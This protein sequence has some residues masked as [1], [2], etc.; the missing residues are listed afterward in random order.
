MDPLSLQDIH[1]LAVLR[2]ECKAGAGVI[3]IMSD[4]GG[5]WTFDIVSSLERRIP[6]DE[7]RSA[8][9]S[10]S[11]GYVAASDSASLF[12]L[13]YPLVAWSLLADSSF[14]GEERIAVF[15]DGA[16]RMGVFVQYVPFCALSDALPPR[17]A[18]SPRTLRWRPR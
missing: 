3:G 16:R 11:L 12:D 15:A 2:E 14:S 5:K 4:G 1:A 6:H 17:S 8:S 7:R 9:C 10:E 13:N 18:G